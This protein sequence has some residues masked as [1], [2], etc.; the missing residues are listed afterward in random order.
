M[1]GICGI[2]DGEA[3]EESCE[4]L[5]RGTASGIIHESRMICT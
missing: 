4:P 2:F 5:V 3:R 1:C